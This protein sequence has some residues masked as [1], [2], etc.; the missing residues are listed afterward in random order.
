MGLVPQFGGS[1]AKLIWHTLPRVSRL[2]PGSRGGPAYLRPRGQEGSTF[3]RSPR[4]TARAPAW[5]QR[6]R[7]PGLAPEESR[8][9]GVAVGGT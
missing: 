8:P 5:I 3:K 1:P 2:S 9:L 7:Y 6:R 4:R